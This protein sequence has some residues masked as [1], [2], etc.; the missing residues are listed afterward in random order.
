MSRI[1]E[2]EEGTPTTTPTATARIIEDGG[3]LGLMV[4]LDELGDGHELSG[5]GRRIVASTMSQ[6]LGV[7]VTVTGAAD[8][9]SGPTERYCRYAPFSAP[10][11][12]DDQAYE[13]VE[14]AL[15]QALDR[16]DDLLA[17]ANARS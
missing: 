4:D 13:E 15:Q 2:L 9:A 14:D 10:W 17:N 16:C 12:T 3:Y 8:I 6:A 5:S 1:A 11:T 7:T